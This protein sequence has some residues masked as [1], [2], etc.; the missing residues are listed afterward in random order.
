MRSRTF[1]GYRRPNNTVG[2]RN[3]VA[4]IPLDDLSNTAALGVSRLIEGTLPLPHPYGRLQFGADLDLFFRTMIG[5]GRNPNVA[6]AVVIGIE[7]NWTSKI[8]DGIAR[9]GKPVAAFSIE[10][11]GDLKTIE[12]AAKAAKD[13]VHKASEMRRE[14][15]DLS[16]LVMSVKCGESDTTSGLA[17]NPTVGR[18]VERMVSAGAT[19]L[20][21]ETSEITGAEHIVADRMKTPELKQEFL[22][23]FNDY[24]S[25]I[26]QQ[27]AD[28]LG[29]QPTQGNITGGLT[30]IEEK[31]MGNI[32]KIG[33]AQVDGVLRSAEAPAGRGLYFMDSSS[34]AAECITLFAA[35]GSV[36]HLFP[37]GQGN[38]V[39]HPVIPVIKLSANPT[40][41]STMSEHIDVDVSKVL[42]LEKTLDQAADDLFDMLMRTIGGRRTAAEVLGHKEFVLTKLF[43]SA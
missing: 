43:R 32:Q 41:V 17:A 27:D 31:A 42:T 26:E 4:I 2:V 3:H 22:N 10:R 36:V 34:A 19:V 21:G 1:M 13:F 14:P 30:T 39:G 6:A 40:T 7:P 8:A 24:V 11:H 9:T 35:G 38:I 37:T 18:V 5:T 12:R 29:S 16:E 25:F 28:L 33:R 20:F 15:A 23:V